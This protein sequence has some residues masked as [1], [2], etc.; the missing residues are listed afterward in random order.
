MFD[1]DRKINRLTMKNVLFMIT[2]TILLVWVILHINDVLS[3]ARMLLDMLRPFLYGIMMA[4][5]FNLP[6]KFFMKKL[7]DQLG[8][9][10]K[11]LAVLLSLAIIA[12]IIG[13]IVQI[14]MPQVI[15]SITTLVNSLP[16][17]IKSIED[18]VDTAIKNQQIPSS[19]LDQVD[20]YTAQLQDTLI[21]LVKNGLPQLLN[22]A[23]GFATSIANMLMAFVIAVYLTISKD[24]LIRQAKQ[25]LYAFTSTKVNAY[26]L[27]VGR[28]TNVTFSNFVAGQL[29][30]AII[31]GLLCYVGCLILRFPYAPILSVIIGVTNVIPI[32]GAIFGV[33]LSAVLVAFV[34]P[35]QG[36]FFVLFGICLQQFESNLIYPRVVGTTVGLSGLWVLFAI[37]IGG[38]LFSFFGMLLGLPT[39]SVIY[40][41]LREEMHRRTQA[42][43]EAESIPQ[44]VEEVA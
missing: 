35:L 41:L 14:V 12:A 25:F 42:K 38:G 43:K 27:K 8:K 34:D 11:P 13:F 1:K 32:F 22:A 4:F 30:E 17:Y 2:Y 31:I 37:T 44:I 19:L 29:M 20:T 23:G 18:M 36:V 26:L 16:T 7:P 3:V 15:A 40:S 28:L 39:F 9:G 10:K 24:K 33:A 6:L 21:S 5:I